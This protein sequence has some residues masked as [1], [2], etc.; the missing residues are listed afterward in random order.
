MSRLLLPHSRP[1][2]LTPS[3]LNG[4]KNKITSPNDH[5]DS[6]P[7]WS[8]PTGTI[9]L[10]QTD[11]F[12]GTSAEK[13]TEH[14]GSGGVEFQ[15]DDLTVTTGRLV[16]ECFYKQVSGSASGRKIS[17]SIAEN[18]W[19]SAVFIDCDATGGYDPDYYGSWSI[20]SASVTASAN[21]FY[22]A[23][24]DFQCTDTLVLAWIGLLNGGSLSYTGDGTSGWFIDDHRLWDY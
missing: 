4:R 14:S 15:N 16:L 10:G 22:K 5:R 11:R 3:T 23:R 17:F 24:I 9:T 8:Q 12:G 19:N 21:G 6:T 7:E 20:N 1:L 18:D 13:I 2:I